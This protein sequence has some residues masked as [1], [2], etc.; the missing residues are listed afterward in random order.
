MTVCLGVDPTSDLIG[1]ASQVRAR[2]PG[3]NLLD[4]GCG[5][6]LDAEVEVFDPGHGNTK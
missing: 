4:A 2:A 5:V 6:Q 3:D 1:G